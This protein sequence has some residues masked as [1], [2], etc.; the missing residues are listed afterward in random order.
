MALKDSFP[1]ARAAY[2]FI[3]LR[4]ETA[5]PGHTKRGGC[6]MKCHPTVTLGGSESGEL[7]ESS[8]L[9]LPKPKEKETSA[10]TQ[11][12]VSNTFIWNAALFSNRQLHEQVPSLYTF[13]IRRETWQCSS[14]P[15]TALPPTPAS[16][17]H[18]KNELTPLLQ[19][20]YLLWVN[21]F[22]SY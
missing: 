5:R 20:L 3:K 6:F 4:V 19:S 15:P 10:H 22:M 17:R 14:V 11:Q 18:F 13:Y 21:V 12:K 1:T 8:S 9:Y 16:G 2:Y 7:Q